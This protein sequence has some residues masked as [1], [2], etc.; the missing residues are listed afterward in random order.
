MI[1]ANAYGHGAPALAR[2][3][4]SIGAEM[5]AVATMAECEQLR[6]AGIQ[7]DI[8]L[9]GAFSP[10]EAPRAIAS[11]IV[12]SV[13]TQEAVVALKEAAAVAGSVARVHIKIDT[14][15]HRVGI[16]PSSL[17]SFIAECE[18]SGLQ[19]NADNFLCFLSQ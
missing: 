15:M 17:D 13:S 12:C 11:K 8:L 6:E 4:V 7:A 19:V 2:H 3:L 10:A 16:Q 14:G 1:K 18:K 5:L 9:L